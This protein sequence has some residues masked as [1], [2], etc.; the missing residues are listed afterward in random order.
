MDMNM[1]SHV[2]L[3]TVHLYLLFV[4]EGYTLEF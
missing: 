3:Y 2:N 1:Q 4:S